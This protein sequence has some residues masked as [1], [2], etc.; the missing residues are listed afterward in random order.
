LEDAGQGRRVAAVAFPLFDTRPEH[1]GLAK[2]TEVGAGLQAFL[3]GEFV[4]LLLAL[5]DQLHNEDQDLIDRV[6]DHHHVQQR[7]DHR[8]AAADLQRG[9]GH[10][11]VQ[12]A[13]LG[14]RG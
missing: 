11:G 8:P 10:A 9:A 3:G 4:F 1:L 14:K 2:R 7:A 13:R 6:G 12:R 5:P